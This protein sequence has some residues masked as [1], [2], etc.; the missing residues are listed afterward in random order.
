MT[1]TK[2]KKV[3]VIT[4]HRALNYGAVL[5]SYALQVF[6]RNNGF[7]SEL[8][9][10]NP[11]SF[12][13]ERRLISFSSPLVLFKSLLKYPFY[14]SK[15]RRFDRFLSRCHL[16]K[17]VLD[18]QALKNKCADYDFLLVGSDQVWNSQWNHDDKAYY[19]D[20]APL[21][22]KYSYAASLGTSQRDAFEAKRLGDYL[23]SFRRISVR[24]KSA[25]ELISSI[26]EREVLTHVDPT[27][28]LTK[29]E[30]MKIVSEVGGRP[31]LLIYTLEED[32]ELIAKATN[33]AKERK[34][35]IIQIKD[36]FRR[37]SSPIKYASCVSPERFVS[38]FAHASLIVTNSFHGL[39][40][41]TIFEKDFIVSPQKRKGAPNDRLYDFVDKFG[42]TN[43]LADAYQ[44]KIADYDL[45][46][47]KIAIE[48]VVRPR[49]WTYFN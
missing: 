14:K 2:S 46:K 38:L 22:K 43:Q 7:D 30:W 6:L 23:S 20:F 39:A 17:P 12:R 29:E 9:D 8:I 18:Y 1:G 5:Q 37:V 16:S 32:S 40:F 31:Y 34:L 35:D 27:L 25:A 45:T 28:L 10:Y 19:L 3:G 48:N 33:I 11:A 4:F 42:L 21:T 47:K 41:S 24:E 49:N 44:G 26:M 15:V 13:K 36:V